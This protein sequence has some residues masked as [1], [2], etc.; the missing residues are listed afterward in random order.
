MKY[1]RGTHPNS[2]KNGFKKGNKLWN[3]PNAKKNWFKKGEH[4]SS[5]TEF[6]KGHLKTPQLFNLSKLELEELYLKQNLSSNKIAKKINLSGYCVRTWLKKYNIPIKNFKIS[7]EK[8]NRICESYLKEYSGDEISKLLK[9]SQQ[10][11]FKILRKNNI[12]IRNVYRSK[13]TIN[14]IKKNRVKQVFSDKD[15]KKMSESK[16][17]YLEE[18]PEAIERMRRQA[19]EYSNRPDVKAKFKELRKTFIIPKKDTSIEVKIQNFLS[20]LHIEYFTHKY[21]SEISHSYQCDIFIPVQKGI[22]QKTIIECDG[23]FWHG[24]P[25]CKLKPYKNIEQRK[26]IDKN[27]TKELIEKG[28]KVI[29]LWE[30]KIKSMKIN[31]FKEILESFK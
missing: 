10:R 12:K 18:H 6:K 1:K 8:E 19:E 22:L 20:L 15:R 31:D 29:R 5:K 28:F 13:R 27:R 2:R 4:T 11:V 16:I 30:H 24:C 7:R 9:V 14:K 23:C 17:K 3:N 25:I 21:I 26:E